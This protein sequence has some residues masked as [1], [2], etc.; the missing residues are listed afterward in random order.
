MIGKE[1][2]NLGEA[3]YSLPKVTII[4]LLAVSVLLAR[5]AIAQEADSQPLLDGVELDYTYT[6]GGRVALSFSDGELSFRWLAGPFA[7]AEGAGFAYHS[8]QIGEDLYL[9]NWHDEEGFGF[10][11]LVIN[12]QQKVLYSSA[13][14]GYGT[15]EEL[16]LFDGAIIESVMR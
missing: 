16:Q 14:L 4:V 10:I 5:S 8:R 3:M 7:G 13:L 12:L 11:T 2:K 6:D 9:V 1:Q 15:E